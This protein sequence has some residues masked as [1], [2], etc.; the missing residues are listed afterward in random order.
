[1]KKN[2]NKNEIRKKIVLGVFLTGG[3]AIAATNPRFGY[4]ILPRIIKLIKYKYKN[5]KEKKKV[6]N[7]FYLLKKENLINIEY[8]GSQMFISLTKEGKEK[9]G[10]YQIDTLEIKK[11]EKWDKKWRV[12]IFDVKEKDRIKREA[13][14]G[15]IIE[16]G[17]YQL[18]RSVWVCPYNFQKE[19]EII[20]SF[21]GFSQNE[22]KIITASEIE[23]D[24]EI[25]LFFGL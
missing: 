8:R 14:R 24:K 5:K 9:A 16:L 25:K 20:R 7:A 6:S 10:K 3:I 2:K 18:Q 1:M 15:K 19:V 11:P 13:L 4:K 17:L 12:L 22:M 23:N 21:F